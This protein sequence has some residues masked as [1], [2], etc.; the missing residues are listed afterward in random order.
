MKADIEYWFVCPYCRS[1][2]KELVVCIV[3][4]WMGKCRIKGDYY[5]IDAGDEDAEREILFYC[6]DCGEDITYADDVLIGLVKL[7]GIEIIFTYVDIVE[8]GVFYVIKD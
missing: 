1:R 2:T 5:K 6:P 3:N 4:T 8:K 7:G